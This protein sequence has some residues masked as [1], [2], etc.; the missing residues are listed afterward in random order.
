MGRGVRAG[1][2]AGLGVLA[3]L[4]GGTAGAVDTKAPDWSGFV[5][6][7][8][9]VG[10]VVKADDTGLTLRVT[11]YATQGGGSRG[12]G[13]GRRPSLS[14]N[15]RNFHNPYSM[16]RRSGGGS[17]P[18]VKEEHHDYV[19]EY[20]PQSLV[21]YKAL[22]AK[23]DEKGRTVPHTDKETH[24]LRQPTGVPGYA[25]TKA[26]VTPGMVVELVLVR[27]K[28]VAAAKA[29]EDDLRVKYVYLLGH[30]KD[31]PAASPSPKADAKKAN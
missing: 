28:T 30:A 12:G 17:R 4:A 2:A 8:D 10:E 21:R 27:D 3:V 22:P 23:L 14:A 5:T 20:V 11:W 9:V 15:H 26:E 6:V 24:D 25:A 31:A 1:V 29:T 13:R 19:L 7:S 18:K 16:M